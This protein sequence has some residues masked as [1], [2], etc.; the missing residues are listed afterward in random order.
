MYIPQTMAGQTSP[1]CSAMR[2]P[3]ETGGDAET[4]NTKKTHK[5]QIMCFDKLVLFSLASFLQP[6]CDQ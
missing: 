2:I 6:S 4:K 5:R 1:A 3:R